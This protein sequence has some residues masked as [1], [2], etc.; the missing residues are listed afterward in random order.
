MFCL[1]SSLPPERTDEPTTLSVLGD[2]S[3]EGSP[4]EYIRENGAV[5]NVRP[6]TKMFNANL[7]C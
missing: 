7:F 5:G 4:L 2:K 1:E 6:I 3:I